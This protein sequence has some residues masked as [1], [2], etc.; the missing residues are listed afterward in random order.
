MTTAALRLLVPEIVLTAAAVAIYLGGAFW[1]VRR[2]WSW[3]AGA[4]I[5]AAAAALWTQHGPAAAGGLLYADQLAW[6]G[7]WLA[8]A[9]GALLVL[10]SSGSIRHTPCA[11]SDVGG[12]RRV[13]ALY[14]DRPGNT[15]SA[16]AW[17]ACAPAARRNTPPRCC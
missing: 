10:L 15:V 16:P 13:P 11:D 4:A 3:L 17:A 1:A 12:T 9:L 7:R 14:A 8:L 2:V 6:L 5:L